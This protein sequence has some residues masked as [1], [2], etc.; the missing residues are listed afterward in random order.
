MMK[1]AHIK[2]S[3]F[4]NELIIQLPIH[5]ADANEKTKTLNLVYR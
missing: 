1:L 2:F 5:F 4:M 3:D